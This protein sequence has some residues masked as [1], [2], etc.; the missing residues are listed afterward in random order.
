MAMDMDAAAE[1]YRTAMREAVKRHWGLYMVEAVVLILAGIAAIVFPVFS[2]ALFVVILGW[3]LIISG[4]AQG[5]GLFGTGRTPNFW[6]QL[7]SVVLAIWVGVLLLRHV[8]EGMLVISLLL[9]VFLMIEG[10]SKIVFAITIRPLPNWGWVLASGVL[11]VFLAV[12]LWGSMPVTGLWLI[13][14]IL[15]VNLIS[16]GASLGVMAWTLHKTAA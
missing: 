12:L 14:L 10:V 3:L 4:V 13:G 2:S 16:M 7:V 1:T 8:G 9:I 5:F 6:L 11:G 15:G